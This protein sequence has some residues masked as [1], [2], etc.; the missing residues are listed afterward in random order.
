MSLRCVYMVWVQVFFSSAWL[1][2][3]GLA[4]NNS[5]SSFFS[6]LQTLNICLFVDGKLIPAFIGVFVVYLSIINLFV[7]RQVAEV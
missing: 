2:T 5:R 1:F 4:V 3:F 6:P 7:Y